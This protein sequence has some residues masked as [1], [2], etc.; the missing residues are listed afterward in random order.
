MSKIQLDYSY[1]T[2]FIKE[3]DLHKMQTKVTEVHQVIED[4][5]GIGSD[6]LGW[7]DLPNR[8]KIADL[9][10]INRVAD[11]V[12]K[13]SDVL[14]VIGIGGS[15]LGAKAVIDALSHSFHNSLPNKTPQVFFAGQNMSAKYYDDL[16]DVLLNRKVSVNVISKSGTTTEPALG[17][18]YLRDILSGSMAK[19]QVRQRI[20]ATTDESKGS[21]KKMADKEG[22]ETFVIPDDVGG[23]YSVLTPV[24][25][26]PIAVA[27]ININELL[28]GARDMEKLLKEPDIMKNPAYMYAAIR[29]MLHTTGNKAIEILT[30]FDPS[31]HYFSEWWKQLYGESEGKDNKSLYPASVDFST[32]L[33]SMG[34]WIQQ[35]TR[36]IFETFL[37]VEKSRGGAQVPKLDEDTDGFN[38]LAGQ[39]F[40]AVNRKAY[41]GVTLAHHDGKVPNMTVLI[42][43]MNAYYMGQLIF[44]FEKACAMSGYLLRVNPFDQ[45]GVEAYKSNMFALL[46]KAGFEAKAKEVNEHLKSV[47]RKIV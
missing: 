27:G 32:D 11:D 28:Q 13:N 9:E 20:I 2:D 34:Q 12:R 5:T 31:L 40:D 19:E 8:V 42:P 47:Q 35:G 22:Y 36:N 1:V 18:R 14:V 38:F 23:R 3:K 4:R 44:F 30:N 37:W 33:H 10:R 39:N 29:F 17:L 43:E 46:G 45:P 25:L 16:K 15:Y 21:L 6:F 26:L 24:G 7:L 41:E